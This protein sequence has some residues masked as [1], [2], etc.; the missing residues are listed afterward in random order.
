MVKIVLGLNLEH[1]ASAEENV[2]YL[3]TPSRSLH[4]V[5]H[6]IAPKDLKEVMEAMDLGGKLI[7][8]EGTQAVGLYKTRASNLRAVLVELEKAGMVEAPGLDVGETQAG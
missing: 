3:A 6:A 2:V 1:A 8:L 5:D 4:E 7:G